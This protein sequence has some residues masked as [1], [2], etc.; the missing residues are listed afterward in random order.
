MN[1]DLIE[2]PIEDD[3]IPYER[4]EPGRILIVDDKPKH[5]QSS[6]S[7]LTEV[8]GHAVRETTSPTEALQ[9]ASDWSPDVILLDIMMPAMNGLELAKLLRKAHRDIALMFVTGKDSSN[10]KIRGMHFGD[11]YLTKPFNPMVLLE[12]V[13]SLL[14]SRRRLHDDATSYNDKGNHYPILEPNTRTVT[15]HSNRAVQLSPRLWEMLHVLVEAEGEV[16]PREQLMLKLWNDDAVNTNLVDVTINRLRQKIE[17]DPTH[18]ELVIAKSR[19]YYFN[20]KRPS[21]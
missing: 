2:Y 12:M 5:S 3:E 16:V 7:V 14:R 17:I 21:R 11:Q 4:I 13:D 6:A 19:G 15:F 20:M 9:I 8:G 10:D 1:D 18:P